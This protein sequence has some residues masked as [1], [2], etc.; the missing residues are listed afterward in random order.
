MAERS[1]HIPQQYISR[2]TTKGEQ[3][4]RPTPRLARRLV[5]G[6]DLDVAEQIELAWAD[7]YGERM[8]EVLVERLEAFSKDCNAGG[9]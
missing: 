5:V 2:R 1:Q 9:S 3:S 6:L 8:P 7:L 4:N